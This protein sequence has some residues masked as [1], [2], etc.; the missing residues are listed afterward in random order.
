MNTPLWTSAALRRAT[1]G[2]VIGGAFEVEGVS[3]DSRT[4][5]KGDLFIA[6]KGPL[7]DGHDHA[8]A[9]LEK[10]A[11]PLIH[12][13]IAGLG[14]ALIV[15]DTFEALYDIARAARARTAADVVAATGS[16]GKTGMK[17]ALAHVLSA[18]GKTHAPVGSF[19]NHWGVPLTLARMPRDTDFAVI[20]IGMNHAGEIRPL[21]KLA[22]PRLAVVTEVQGVHME[23]FESVA[24]IARAKA[25][26]FEGLLPG[27][28]AVLPHDNPHF[29]LLT[30]FALGNG[31][32]RVVSFGRN[33]GAMLSLE[34]TV[35]HDTCTC[36]KAIAGGA[37]V[38]FKL[39]LVGDHH[40]RNA[41]AVLAVAKEMTGDMARAAIALG[42]LTPPKGRGVRL[43]VQA[44][45]G[46][47]LIIDESYNA[48]PP[49][50]RAMFE[51]L[52]ATKTKRQ[53]RRI[54]LLGDMKELG[55]VSAAE[56]AALASHASTATDMVIT[57]G[58]EM[59]ALNR[60]L[61]KALRGPHFA[62]AKKA[63]AK[64]PDLINANDVLAI[65]GSRSVGLEQIIAAFTPE[66]TPHAV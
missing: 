58:P 40:A 4:A 37:P 56:H 49:S 34:R 61:P 50:M 9:A 12:Q 36:V 39:G 32:S 22:R 45:R 43:K 44:G 13:E 8:L 15:D 42:T 29:D 19:N 21:T 11:I 41:L 51:V 17:E 66:E 27:G 31:A 35:P 14:R 10:G 26:I 55:D 48:S 47:A 28:I 63:A 60:A 52:A 33:E 1:R 20:E 2:K 65:K 59:K 23:F 6:L 5:Q 54:A 46:T 25:E 3:I 57:V 7:H 62:D 64:V 24:E 38:T 18:C 16:V 30:D 53:G